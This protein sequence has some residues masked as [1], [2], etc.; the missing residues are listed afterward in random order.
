MNDYQ[1]TNDNI[2]LTRNW[3]FKD[4][5]KFRSKYDYW[6]TKD[7]LIKQKEYYTFK[8]FKNNALRAY[9]RNN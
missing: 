7:R 2:S 3:T 9:L 8:R 4:W 1:L 5:K 6:E